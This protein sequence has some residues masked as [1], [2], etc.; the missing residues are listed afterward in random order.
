MH[1]NLL[2]IEFRLVFSWM[3]LSNNITTC[4]FKFEVKIVIDEI[5]GRKLS[6]HF[7][8]FCKSKSIFF[9]S[10]FDFYYFMKSVLRYLKFNK[11]NCIKWGNRKM[12]F[13]LFLLDI[14]KI[15]SFG[16]FLFLS[17]AVSKKFR[18][19]KQMIVVLMFFT[20]FGFFFQ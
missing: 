12:D 8:W 14:S 20:Y 2:L 7:D 18:F 10:R 5:S 15:W 11:N 1:I 13:S 4:V 19:I 16:N 17:N 9:K 6:K 3:T